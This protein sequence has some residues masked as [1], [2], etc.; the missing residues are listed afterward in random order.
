MEKLEKFIAGDFS[1]V[2]FEK[3]SEQLIQAK[4]DRD[5][6]KD[7]ALKLETEYQL[8]RDT[9]PDISPKQKNRFFI[10]SLAAALLLLLS[11]FFLFPSKHKFNYQQLVDQQIAQLSIMGD[12]SFLRK[13]KQTVD[14]IRKEATLAYLDQQYDKSIL[15][16]QKIIASQKATGS[17][18]FY[19]A[20]C[21]LKKPESEPQKTIQSILKA[22]SLNG[23]QEEMAWVL[24]LAQIKTGDLQK[25]R[26]GLSTIVEQQNYKAKEAKKILDRLPLE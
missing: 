16:W 26:L 22:Q 18:Y 11:L 17:D 10:L 25:A 13:G 14:H 5:K 6:K 4:L 19:L 15:N 21:Q 3:I 24:A 1:D 2:E 20:L 8:K 9:A 7:W 23:P 12:Q